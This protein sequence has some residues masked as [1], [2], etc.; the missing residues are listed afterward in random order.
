MVSGTYNVGMQDQAFLG[1][2]AGL[3]VPDG[4]G[5]VDLYVA[6]QWLH[7]DQRQ[8]CAALGL[9]P[10]QVRLT[11]A[12]VGGAFGGREDLSMHVHACLLALHTGKPVKMVYN[13]EESFFGHV[14]R[15]PATM[16]YEHGAT[17]DGQL[18]YVQGEIYLDGGAYASSTPAVVGNA[19]TMGI[20]PYVVPNVRVDAYGVYTNNPPCGAMRGF[21]SVQTA[22]AYEAQMDKLAAGSAWTRSS[23]AAAT[24]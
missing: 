12:G 18:V 4:D 17:R 2:E 20:G 13:R 24:P 11:L 7:V 6:T 16:R 15:H 5:G 21:G 9:P 8:I 3:A 1:P 22:F 10:E 19:G 14:H 23:C